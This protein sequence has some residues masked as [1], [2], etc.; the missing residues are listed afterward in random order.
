MRTLRA[1]SAWQFRGKDRFAASSSELIT[2]P[3][4]LLSNSVSELAVPV[5]VTMNVFRAHSII[6]GVA[7]PSLLGE[8]L[9]LRGVMAPV[10]LVLP[11]SDS[12]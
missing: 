9:L 6:R 8:I 3:E 5:N 12:Q 4:R 11:R 7:V 1:K 10:S 2:L